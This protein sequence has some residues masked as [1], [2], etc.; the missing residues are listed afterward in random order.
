MGVVGIL[1]VGFLA[2]YQLIQLPKRSTQLEMVDRQADQIETIQ[3]NLIA[4]GYMP[5]PKR[6]KKNRRKVKAKKNHGRR[7]E[8]KQDKEDGDETE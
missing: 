3:D 2:H 4:H 6:F 7:Q 1:I 5:A 8:Q